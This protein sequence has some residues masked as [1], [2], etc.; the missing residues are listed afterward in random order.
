MR[1]LTSAEV[2]QIHGNSM[3]TVQNVVKAHVRHICGASSLLGDT[4][5]DVAGN[6]YGCGSMPW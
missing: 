5:L 6:K 2:A 1:Q 3:T 4:R